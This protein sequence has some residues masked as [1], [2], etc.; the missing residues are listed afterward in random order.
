M[1][2]KHTLLLGLFAL[3]PLGVAAQ[4]ADTDTAKTAPPPAASAG[5]AAPTTEER[6]FDITRDGNKIGT[7]VVDITRDG[8]K[9]TVKFKTHIEVEIMFVVVH[10][11]DHIA[12]EIWNGGKF[13][14]YKAFTKENSDVNKLTAAAEGDKIALTVNG[15]EKNVDGSLVFASFWNRDF[16]GQKT[17]L[18]QDTGRELSVEV[19]DLGD[20]T[21]ALKDGSSVKARHYKISGDL[22]R[23]LWF[24]G[25]NLVRIK[26]FGSDHSTIVSELTSAKSN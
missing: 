14:S 20:D 15:E 19:A 25:D 7:Q 10:R 26:L 23:D 16:V 9:T 24:D 22:E 8:D 17:L 18:H 13:V 3:F 21:I 1:L 6:V 11:F 4:S 5:L 12:T 2:G